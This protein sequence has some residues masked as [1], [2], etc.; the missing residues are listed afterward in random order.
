[1]PKRFDDAPKIE[2]IVGINTGKFGSSPRMR[3]RVPYIELS[4]SE[5]Q[6]YYSQ[7]GGDILFHT[8]D[9]VP[10]QTAETIFKDEGVLT[11]DFGCGRGERIIELAKI[12]S[13]RMFVG[14]DNH[15]RSLLIG[16]RAASSAELN[17]VHFVRA[18]A[19][20]L[21]ARIPE[22][23]AEESDVLFPAPLPSP[24]GYKDI[25]QTPF[26][27]DIHRV[28][29]GDGVF[30]FATDSEPYFDY[31]MRLIGAMGLFLVD[32]GNITHE[33]ESGNNSVNENT[34]TRYQRQ[35]ES[36]GI[37]TNRAKMKKI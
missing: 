25:L 35:W 23:S 9:L 21:I 11:W 17:N 16:A 12:Y 15:T 13:T 24:R 8:P 3:E 28:L 30:E 10:F 5:R 20:L 37:P 33:V 27:K 4:P 34:A 31:K 29:Y 7:F 1:M 14:V 26:V 22:E 18:D 32:P 36:K 19:K 6:K 2:A